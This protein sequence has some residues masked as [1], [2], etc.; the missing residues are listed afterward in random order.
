[1][2][3]S[4]GPI[5]LNIWTFEEDIFQWLSKAADGKMFNVYFKSI[6]IL[7][8]HPGVLKNIFIWIETVV[9]SQTTISVEKTIIWITTY[10]TSM[11]QTSQLQQLWVWHSIFP[12]SHCIL[13]TMDIFTNV[14]FQQNSLIHVFV[15]S[16]IYK[17]CIEHLLYYMGIYLQMKKRNKMVYNQGL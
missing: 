16:L 7:D 13:L 6:S 14:I 10:L 17:T 15:H 12:T 2:P 3:G 4:H 9:H 1:M 8:S 5:N 11:R